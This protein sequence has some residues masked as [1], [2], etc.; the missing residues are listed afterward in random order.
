MN[1]SKHYTPMEKKVFLQILEKYKHVIEVKKNDGA[2]LKDKDVAWSEICNQYNLST[3]ICHERAVQQL[4]KLWANLKQCQREALTKEKQSVMATGGGPQEATVD[5]DPD[6]ARIAPHLMKTAPVL[7]TSNMSEKEVNDKRDFVFDLISTDQSV[8]VLSN[9]E[10][11]YSIHIEDDVESTTASQ[12]GCNKELTTSHNTDMPEVHSNNDNKKP[13][14][15]KRKRK[16]LPEVSNVE[17]ELR[18]QRIKQIMKQNE[19]LAN[20]K[21]KHEERITVMKEEHLKEF[22]YMQLKHLKEVQK[23]EIQINKAK[24]RIIDCQSIDKE[25]IDPHV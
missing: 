24:L 12:E 17:E 13:R 20:I 21:L 25:N 23:L 11:E 5:I 1:K 19:Q 9:H 3:L 18:I 8:E 2:T 6:I 7:F 4:K 15:L 14:I 10:D 16:D 22:N